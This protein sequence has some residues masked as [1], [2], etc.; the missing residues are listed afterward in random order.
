VASSWEH[1]YGP[2]DPVK[3]RGISW[4]AERLLASQGRFS[5]WTV[6]SLSQHSLGA[7][8]TVT[9]WVSRPLCLDYKASTPLRRQTCS[10]CRVSGGGSHS[11]RNAIVVLQYFLSFTTVEQRNVFILKPIWRFRNMRNNSKATTVGNWKEVVKKH[12]RNGVAACSI[13]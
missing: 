12:Q 9:Q 4:L 1:D 11:M 3:R 5:M 6:I 7:S 10:V 2:S 13:K 8:W